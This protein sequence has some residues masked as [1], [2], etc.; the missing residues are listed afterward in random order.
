[1]HHLMIDICANVVPVAA[2]LSPSSAPDCAAAFGGSGDPIALETVGKP[3]AG[4]DYANGEKA[5][6]IAE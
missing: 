4:L 3:R 6:P 5:R 2:K 1:M